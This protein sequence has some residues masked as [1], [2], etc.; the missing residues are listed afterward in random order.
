MNLT[1]KRFSAWAIPKMN[2]QPLVSQKLA[3]AFIPRKRVTLAVIISMIVFASA[4]AQQSTSN[5]PRR[6]A[7][8]Q[9]QDIESRLLPPT[10]RITSERKKRTA[11]QRAVDKADTRAYLL[12]IA[13]ELSSFRKQNPEHPKAAEARLNEARSLLIA[14]LLGDKSQE[15]RIQTTVEEVKADTRLTSHDRFEIVALA[16]RLLVRGSAKSREEASV[17]NEAS[18]RYLIREFPKEAGSYAELLHAA[19]LA[20]SPR[21]V[22]LAQQVVD[23]PAPES[24]KLA[25]RDIIT[26]QTIPGK[27][28]AELV[29]G[30]P[31]AGP[32]IKAAL[33]RSLIIYTWRP[34][35]QQSVDRAKAIMS[36]IPANALVLGVNVGPDAS[37]ALAFAKLNN[38][39]GEQLYGARGADS[40]VVLRLALTASGMLYV[41]GKDGRMQNLSELRN[42]VQVLA[43][44]N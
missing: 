44:L 30:Q 15:S 21:A 24:L 17:A 23:S 36:A 14:A 38:L 19:A 37:A 7:D 31:G 42:P 26:R 32:L 12:A 16:E 4:D 34:E 29:G 11:E 33:G 40:P 13:D 5:S 22:A 35:D 39:P 18:A 2:K 28:F 25:A 6:N 9:W 10:A 41:A 20:S 8:A 27:T 1:C 3:S 43:N